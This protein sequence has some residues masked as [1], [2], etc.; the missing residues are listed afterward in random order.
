MLKPNMNYADLKDSYLFYNISQKIASYLESHP[1][2]RLLRLGIGDVTLPLCDAV[3]GA[4][5][6]AV[7]WHRKNNVGGALGSTHVVLCDAS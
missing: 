4:L 7:L 2:A 3:I 5:K 6:G 1:G